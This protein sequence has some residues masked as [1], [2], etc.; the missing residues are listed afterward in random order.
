VAAAA[1]GALLLIPTSAVAL[2]PLP[3]TPES[4]SQCLWGRL[5]LW[6][7]SNYTGT[8]F[9]TTYGQD[10][11][12]M[13]MAQSLWNRTPNAV[14]IYSGTGGSGTSTCFEP[15]DQ[16]ASTAIWSGSVRVL[17]TTAC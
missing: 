11:T 7:A 1:A 15:D 5:C 17:A 6:S 8:V 4:S 12:G 2:D 16:I 3:I 9:A 10:V 14:R 13:S